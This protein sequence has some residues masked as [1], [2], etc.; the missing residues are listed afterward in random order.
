MGLIEVVL[1]SSLSSLLLTRFAGRPL[2]VDAS[3]VSESE[4]IAVFLVLRMRSR[5]ALGVRRLLR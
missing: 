3:E 1:P 2:V 4:A 5:L